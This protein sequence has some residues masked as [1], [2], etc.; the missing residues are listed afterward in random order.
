M[1]IPPI[2][3]VFGYR[4]QLRR[5]EFEVQTQVSRQRPRFWF[6]AYLRARPDR[7]RLLRLRSLG[8]A[9]VRVLLRALWVLRV[10]LHPKVCAFL[11]AVGRWA[12][13][14]SFLLHRQALGLLLACQD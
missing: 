5:Y 7:R 4:R 10:E 2:P 3:L 11:S 6:V 8:S 1:T 12:A 14:A 9:S 13:L